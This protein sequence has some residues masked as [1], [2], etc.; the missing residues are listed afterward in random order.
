MATEERNQKSRA[1]VV[2]EKKF[3]RHLRIF[4]D[5]PGDFVTMGE[6]RRAESW[7]G[8]MGHQKSY[9]VAF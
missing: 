6:K 3:I 8:K 5:L 7:A 4:P 1:R 2:V 9:G